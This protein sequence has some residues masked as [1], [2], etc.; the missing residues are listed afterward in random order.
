MAQ[1]VEAIYRNG[2]IE[3][4]EALYLPDSQRLRVTIEPIEGEKEPQS[5]YDRIVAIL[6]RA[7]ARRWT[8][9]MCEAVF[10]PFQPV[11]LEEAERAW[12]KLGGTLSEDI[13]RDR[14]EY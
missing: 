5:E 9:E 11:D 3:L 4:L 8:K 2:V 10:G 14:G 7:G 13:I 1:T 12:A 6:E